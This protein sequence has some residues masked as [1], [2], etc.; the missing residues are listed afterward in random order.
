ML[1]NILIVLAIA[2]I[3][4]SYV[5]KVD[6]SP[7]EKVL[8]MLGDLQAEVVTEG[9]AEAETYD[10]YACFC[11]DVSE[12]K[13]KSIEEQTAEQESLMATIEKETSS[14]TELDEKMK[15]ATNR[16]GEIDAEIKKAK[17]ER[18]AEKLT[19][20][21]NVL[22]MEGALQALDAAIAELK[23]AKG[24]VSLAQVKSMLKN[25]R[26]AAV[27]ADALGVGD[28]KTK[29][30]LKPLL[31]DQEDP[32]YE[33]QSEEIIELLEKLL[34][35]FKS[36][37]SDIDE[38]EVK[39]VE[40]HDKVIEALKEEK[41]N[42]TKELEDAKADKATAVET[43]TEKSGELSTISATLLDDQEYLKDVSAKCN[44]KAKLWEERTQARSDELGAISTAI[45]IIK[46]VAPKKDELIQIH[47]KDRALPANGDNVQ[48]KD[49]AIHSP[50]GFLQVESKPLLS[51]LSSKQSEVATQN[52]KVNAVVSLLR[53]EAQTLK[54]ELLSKLAQ[55][56]AADPFAKIKKLIQELIERLLQ[57]AADEA[58]HKGWC[59][60]EM[61]REKQ[62]RGYKV[63]ELEKLNAALASAE[64]LRDKLSE[65]VD[66]LT[67][68]TKNLGT[69]L[70]KATELRDKRRRRTR[71]Q[72]RR[73]KKP[74]R[75]SLK[76]LGC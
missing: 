54:S 18:H 44:E 38:E 41:S 33:F 23:A 30:A 5:E 2:A 32:I 49:V 16:L 15:D 22:D 43:I 71:L 28:A 25:V 26:K 74:R 45:S 51:A 1:R 40:A 59:D 73:P 14:R 13:S 57:E 52:E 48:E 47:A 63:E 50:L 58:S 64:A 10:K 20:D 67:K 27:L 37:K 35:D 21:A 66:T 75:L 19:Y 3:E 46:G 34:K 76:Q 29:M 69:E 62:T 4:A 60:K 9:K 17:G 42:K 31:L 11:K 12:E 72:S 56:V 36:E 68:D 8:T 6:G 55:R 53:S 61:S 65:E 70:E 39:A 7:I 24:A